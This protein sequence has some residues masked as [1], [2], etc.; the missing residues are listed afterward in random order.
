MHKEKHRQ[1]RLARLRR[2]HAFPEHVELDIAFLRPVFIAPYFI[3]RGVRFC[4][5]ARRLSECLGG[6]TRQCE[7]AGNCRT[8]AQEKISARRTAFCEGH[9]YLQEVSVEIVRL[10]YSLRDDFFNIGDAVAVR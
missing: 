5:R 10:Q 7:P 2:A 4:L 6:N 1:G 9:D 3:V 8:R